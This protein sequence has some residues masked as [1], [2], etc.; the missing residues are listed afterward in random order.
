[1]PT[2]IPPLVIRGRDGIIVVRASD[3]GLEAPGFTFVSTS[4]I[5][6]GK[7]RTEVI[8]FNDE[9]MTAV[10]EYVNNHRA[11]WPPSD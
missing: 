5:R 2:I 11:N 3:T 6:G 4:T 9:Q 1:M 7:T 8:D 10:L